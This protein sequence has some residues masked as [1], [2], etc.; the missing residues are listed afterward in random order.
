M[1]IINEQLSPGFNRYEFRCRCGCGAAPVDQRLVDGL[2]AIRAIVK[3]PVILTCG[4]RCPKHN[5]EVPGAS[6]NSR[7]MV[8]CAADICVAGFSPD[9]LGAIA[10]QIRM[11]TGIGIYPTRGFVHVEVGWKPRKWRKFS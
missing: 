4:Y 9:Q 2:E 7:H 6:S 11:F 10:K 8:G 1:N 3:L 5:R